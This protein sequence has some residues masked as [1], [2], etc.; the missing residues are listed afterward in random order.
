VVIKTLR[1]RLLIVMKTYKNSSTQPQNQNQNNNQEKTNICMK[2]Y[3]SFHVRCSRVLK[4]FLPCH[5]CVCTY[6][7]LIPYHR[8]HFLILFFYLVCIYK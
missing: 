8:N 7:T 2:V 6:I 4:Q 5:R 3:N 1:N